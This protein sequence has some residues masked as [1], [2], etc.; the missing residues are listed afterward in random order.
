MTEPIYKMPTPR[1]LETCPTCGSPAEPS[2]SLP[3]PERPGRPKVRLACGH[4]FPVGKL[5][6]EYQV[7]SSPGEP[8]PERGE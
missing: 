7:V 4:E 6:L 1:K 5:T 2:E 3:D 8:S